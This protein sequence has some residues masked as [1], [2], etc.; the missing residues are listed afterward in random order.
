MSVVE[1][2]WV[3]RRDPTMEARIVFEDAESVEYR[4]RRVGSDSAGL[5]TGWSKA[6]FE[7]DYRLK[8]GAA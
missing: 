5:Y 6:L 1:W 2:P 8:A 4:F 7:A 3:S